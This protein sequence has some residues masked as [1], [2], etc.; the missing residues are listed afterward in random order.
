MEQDRA[1]EIPGEVVIPE[2]AAREFDGSSDGS[3]S[4]SARSVA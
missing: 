1:E 3:L 2:I 4:L